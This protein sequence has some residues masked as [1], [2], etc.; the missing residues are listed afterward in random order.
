M[1]RLHPFRTTFKWRHL[2]THTQGERLFIVQ[3]KKTTNVIAVDKGHMG[4]RRSLPSSSCLGHP[5]S[6]VHPYGVIA[7]RQGGRSNDAS[8]VNQAISFL[9]DWN[10][11]SAGT[12]ID[13][14]SAAVVQLSQL[15]REYEGES[16]DPCLHSLQDNLRA[17]PLSG[18]EGGKRQLGREIQL[19]TTIS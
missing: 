1:K 15:P 13:F 16:W 19:K 9:R 14:P 8:S 6:L 2:N 3:K 12:T 17:L 4:R 11:D 10:E 18:E 7:D 5:L